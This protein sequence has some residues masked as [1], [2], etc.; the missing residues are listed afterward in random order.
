[1]RFL[2]ILV[3]LGL[4]FSLVVVEHASACPSCQVAIESTG[5]GS[6]ESMSNLSR[7]Y[8]Q[9]IYLFMSMPFLLLGTFGFLIYRGVKQNE[10]YR[11]S[12]TEQFDLSDNIQDH[13]QN[14]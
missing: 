3:L 2:S 10:A 6:D 5:D 14:R 11:Q 4:M 13:S 8:N 7:A 12:H 1:M 9:S